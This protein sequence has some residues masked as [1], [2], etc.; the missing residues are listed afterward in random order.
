MHPEAVNQSPLNTLW[1]FNKK[2]KVFKF[3]KLGK[4]VFSFFYNEQTRSA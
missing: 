3:N 1:K 4:N 2:T